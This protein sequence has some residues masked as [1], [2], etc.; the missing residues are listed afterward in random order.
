[1]QASSV[2]PSCK[3]VWGTEESCQHCGHRSSETQNPPLPRRIQSRVAQEWR[4]ARQTFSRI[5]LSCKAF[6]LKVAAILRE[7]FPLPE[8]TSNS[9]GLQPEVEQF[10]EVLKWEDLFLT[11]A[12]A[13]GDGA[14]W[15]IF[16]AKYQSAI[17]ATALRVAS[18]PV[19]ASD[20]GDTLMTDLFLP[21]AAIA[22]GRECKIGQYHGMGSLEGWVKVVIHRLAIDR[23]R[24]Q[25]KSTSLEALE[26]E[27][28]SRD[29][30]SRAERSV[31]ERDT[32]K[33]LRMVSGALTDA[34]RQ[35]DTKERLALSLYYVQGLSLKEISRWL[36]AH[37]S[38][39]SRL[40]DRLREQL[41]KSVSRHLQEKF[42]VKKSEIP[43]LVQL[44]QT[45]L[46]LDLKRVLNE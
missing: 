32:Q 34:L 4:L 24:V 42:K 27:P 22:S 12:C 36:K 11:T 41:R 6:E 30:T 17:R 39:A 33:A 8:D 18:N 13:A 21:G 37:E 45:D 16:Q 5:N 1:M 28:V 40:L 2:C 44:A 25:H 19:D 14:A 15:E 7:R 20:L 9:G 3:Q 23:F 29:S 46:D 38:T 10:I 35:L 26:I 31:E 43:H